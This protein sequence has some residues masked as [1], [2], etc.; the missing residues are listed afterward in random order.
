MLI[1]IISDTHDNIPN[2]EKALT[3]FTKQGIKI[4]LHCGDICAPSSFIK[5]LVGKFPGTIHHVFGNVDGD[6]FLIHKLTSESGRDDVFLH[7]EVAEIEIDGKKIAMNHYPDI[8]KRLAESSAY[9]LVC[10]GHNH[11]QAVETVGKTVLL[12][13]GTL[14]GL[15]APATL[16][17]YDTATGEVTLLGIND[18]T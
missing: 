11:T 16:A 10:Y 4:I 8:A 12:N 6:R 18:I 13:P 15:F 1:G 7:G 17:T 2:I 5:T 3:W 14:G 9:D